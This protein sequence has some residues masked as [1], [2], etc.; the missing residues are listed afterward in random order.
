M[1]S[2]LVSNDVVVETGE[3]IHCRHQNSQLNEATKE[4]T[5]SE[6]NMHPIKT[7]NLEQIIFFPLKAVS[8]LTLEIIFETLE[9]KKNGGPII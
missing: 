9:T 1:V 4:D 7:Q 3:G 8:A 6:D 5:G 2:V